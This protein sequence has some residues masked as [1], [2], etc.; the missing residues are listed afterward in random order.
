MREEDFPLGS[1]SD[2][3]IPLSFKYL[4]S[5]IVT[6]ICSVSA[7]FP[8]LQQLDDDGDIMVVPVKVPPPLLPLHRQPALP[9]NCLGGLFMAAPTVVLKSA[10]V[11]ALYSHGPESLSAL[12]SDRR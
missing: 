9:N 12:C 1:S 2:A 10:H 7:P 11:M 4:G 6:N 8:F 3:T 5:G